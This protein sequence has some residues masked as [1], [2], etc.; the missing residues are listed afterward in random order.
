[1]QRAIVG[2][3]SAF[4]HKIGGATGRI[5]FCWHDD[6]LYSPLG[7]DPKDAQPKARGVLANGN[8]GGGLDEL[9][10]LCRSSRVILETR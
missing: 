5:P 1:M 7:E 3:P 9:L 10:M 4:A 2:L 6:G 8:N